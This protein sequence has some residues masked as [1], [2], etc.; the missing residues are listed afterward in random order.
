[1]DPWYSKN[2]LAKIRIIRD[3]L[4]VAITFAIIIYAYT[5]KYLSY[6][7]LVVPDTGYELRIESGTSVRQ[8]IKHLHS[9]GLLSHPNL[10]IWYV[11]LVGANHIQAG[12]YKVLPGM[13]PLQLLTKVES[14][15]VEQYSFTIIEGWST[16]QL[17]AELHKHPKIKHTLY[18]LSMQEMVQKL[19][20]Q[21]THLEGV[22]LP[23]TY[24]FLADTTD[25]EFLRRAYF[26]MEHK[27]RQSW[28]TRSADCGVKSPYEALILA[29]IIEKESGI[30]K[31]YAEISGVFSRRLAKNMKL[32]AD[33]TVIYAY[34]SGLTEP[35]ARKH[36][37]IKSP[38]NTY[39]NV[40]LPP[41]PIALP[42]ALAIDAALHPAQGDALYFVATGEGGHVFSSNLKD[43]NAA[44]KRLY[45][46][47]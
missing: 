8:F 23:N 27:L 5:W 29:S 20:I 45:T 6:D 21:V 10:M 28:P 41:T 11:A 19:N 33:P 37:N 3:C 32:Q 39:Q 38:Y 34:E 31:E 47:K 18:G 42:S 4:I 43:H 25:V 7:P 26:S 14:G 22:F 1:M 16:A 13:T 12:E 2:T 36:L 30:I 9:S 44:V 15:L 46:R 35:L 40:G 24:N 17:L